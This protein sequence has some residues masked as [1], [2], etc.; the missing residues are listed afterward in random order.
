MTA[1]FVDV[2]VLVFLRAGSEI[3]WALFLHAILPKPQQ[4]SNAHFLL[5]ARLY[6]KARTRKQTV[7]C[8]QKK[9]VSSTGNKHLG[10][11]LPKPYQLGHAHLLI[12]FDRYTRTAK[13]FETGKS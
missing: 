2:E 13:R 4:M 10:K 11:S 6:S 8:L 3:L 12:L 5:T 1:Y 7:C 9:A